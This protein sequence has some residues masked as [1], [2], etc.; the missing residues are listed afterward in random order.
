M[1]RRWNDAQ[2]ERGGNLN[3]WSGGCCVYF[4]APGDKC[5]EPQDNGDGR[6]GGRDN[7]R[8]RYDV[9]RGSRYGTY[10]DDHTANNDHVVN[11]SG[12]DG[13]NDASGCSRTH[14]WLLP[15]Y[16]WWQLL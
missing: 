13:L 5:R 15:A 2:I 11:G 3:S 4:C 10:N 7:E 12:T 6:C 1:R 14:E 8:P 16:Q 9:D